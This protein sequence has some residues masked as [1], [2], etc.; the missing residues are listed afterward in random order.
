MLAL[1]AIMGSLLLAGHSDL[2]EY[3]CAVQQKVIK[4]RTTVTRKMLLFKEG[5][6]KYSECDLFTV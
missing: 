1:F 6:M 2:A 5:P 4:T 3:D